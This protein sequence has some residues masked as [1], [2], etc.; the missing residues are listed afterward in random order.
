MKNKQLFIIKAYR[1]DQWTKIYWFF[2]RLYL[3]SICK[4]SIV[5]KISLRFPIILF[6]IKCSI[7]DK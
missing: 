7:F 3:L 6:D 4:L 1:P 2:Q 5:D